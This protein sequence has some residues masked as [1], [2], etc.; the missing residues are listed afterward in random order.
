[1]STT[2]ASPVQR[3]RLGRIAVYIQRMWPPQL[4]L[5]ANLCFFL[6]VYLGLQSLHAGGSLSFSW[7]ALVGVV[8]VQL[9]LLLVRVYDELKDGESDKE[10]ALAGDPKFI[11]RPLVTGE[12]SIEDIIL[13]R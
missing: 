10:F 1:M 6:P 9:L 5:P 7:K 11:D 12:V 4:R 8:T 2:V 3:G 13:L